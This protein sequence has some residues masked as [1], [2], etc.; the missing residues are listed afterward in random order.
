MGECSGIRSRLHQEDYAQSFGLFPA[1]KYERNHSGTPGAKLR[2]MFE[3]TR[4]V[5]DIASVTRLLQHVIFN[6]IACNTDAHA[7]NYSLLVSASGAR[8][9]PLYD[10]MC[11]A[12]W[13]NITKN[14]ANTIA[15]KVRGDYLKGRHWQR[16][17]ALCGLSPAATLRQVASLCERVRGALDDTVAELIA[18]D[19]EAEFMADACRT[20]IGQRALF[21]SN[22]LKDVD[23]DL[24]GWIAQHSRG[25]VNMDDEA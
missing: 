21:L 8:L 20:E 25:A 1:A 18:M 22:G 19:P 17:A 3:L 14:M 5:A 13:P 4:Q 10:V 7:K 15:G 24:K 16:E 6:V 9:A 11:G 23:P 12:V 2:D